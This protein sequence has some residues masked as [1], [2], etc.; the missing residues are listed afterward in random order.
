MELPQPSPLTSQGRS[1]TLIRLSNPHDLSI[2]PFLE[3]CKAGDIELVK[4]LTQPRDRTDGSLTLGLKVAVNE[5]HIGIARYLLENGAK[6]DSSTVDRAH[7]ISALEM[8]IEHGFGVNDPLPFGYVVL[9][10]IVARNDEPFVRFL[11]SHGANPN[12]GPPVYYTETTVAAMR[13]SPTS[14]AALGAAAANATPA[15]F[16]LLLSHGANLSYA[17]PL[18]SAVAASNRPPG[19]RVPMM[20]YLVSLGVDING[21]D[22]VMGPARKGTPLLYAALWQRVEEARWLLERGADPDRRMTWGNTPREYVVRMKV[23]KMIELFSEYGSKKEV[24]VGQ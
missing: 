3:A 11:L 21:N 24:V 17:I 20:A 15:I 1:L 9:P 23:G 19:E 2:R 13:P 18:H 5:D 7:S 22:D 4:R 14:G 16:S 8:L 12:L 10:A 6:W